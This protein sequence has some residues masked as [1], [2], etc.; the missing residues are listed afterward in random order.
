MTVSAAAIQVLKE[1]GRP[2]HAK[3]ITERIL[4]R[5]LWSSSG[6]TPGATVRMP[7]GNAEGVRLGILVSTET[8]EIYGKPH[9][10]PYLMPIRARMP[11]AGNPMASS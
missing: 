6:K 5:G 10:K 8:G 2:L 7:K 1:A 3:E 11:V 9:Y 4:S